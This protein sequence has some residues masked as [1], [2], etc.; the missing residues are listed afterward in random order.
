LLLFSILLDDK[1][2]KRKYLQ[3]TQGQ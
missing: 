3:D 2:V 1:E